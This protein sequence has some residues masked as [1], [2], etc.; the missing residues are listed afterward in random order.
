MFS[1]YLSRA[2]NIQA[3]GYYERVAESAKQYAERLLGSRR[4]VQPAQQIEAI[5]QRLVYTYKDHGFVID[6]GE[7]AE[8]FGQGVVRSDSPEYRFANDLY[9]TLDFAEWLI[10]S[11]FSRGFSYVG[12][13]DAALAFQR[14]KS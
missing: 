4:E 6:A 7:A 2:L 10:D 1:D 12:G 13:A 8:I 9:M 11:E 5:A 3:L 14:T